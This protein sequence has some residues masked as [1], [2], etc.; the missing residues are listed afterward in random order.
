[1]ERMKMLGLGLLDGRSASII[2]R[3]IGRLRFFLTLD[4][5]L[6]FSF[7]ERSCAAFGAISQSYFGNEPEA[8]IR[9]WRQF[10]LLQHFAE[11]GA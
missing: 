11:S 1:M 9:Y 7:E 3:R 2:S 10:G 5:I 4:T 8:E 6:D